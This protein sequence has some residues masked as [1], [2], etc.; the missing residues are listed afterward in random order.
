MPVGS[1]S[2]KRAAGAETRKRTR[3]KAKPK[4]ETPEAEVKESV[5]VPEASEEIQAKF[6]SQEAKDSSK[7]GN[8]SIQIKEELPVYLL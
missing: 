5:V 2:I 4:T 3:A 6:V 7:K 8:G 1:E